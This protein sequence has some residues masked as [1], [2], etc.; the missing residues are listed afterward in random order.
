MTNETIRR[1]LMAYLSA[2]AML[3]TISSPV[4][5]QSFD[6]RKATTAVEKMIC[7]NGEL[8]LLDEQLARAFTDARKSVAASAIGQVAWLR[9]VR[10]QCASV[11]CLKA[12]HQARI[13]VLKKQSP[14]AP[15]SIDRLAGEWTRVGDTPADPSTLTISNATTTGF[16]FEVSAASGG[17]SGIIEGVAVRDDAEAVFKDRETKCNVRF[18][19]GSDYLFLSPSPD[20][21][22]MGGMGVTFHGEYRKGKVER[23]TP[24]L[25]ELGI[26]AANVTEKAFSAL[27]GKDYELFL[28][29]FHLRSDETDLDGLGA[30]VVSGGVRGLYTFMEAIVMSRSD[31]TI[32]AALI[33][34]DVVKYFSND[35]K[36]KTKL[37]I[38]IDKWRGNFA[39]KKVIFVP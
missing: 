19:W 14:V 33:D 17:N 11:D 7:A 10:N 8:S 15:L 22:S 32:L 12:A 34:D 31:G 1:V 38:T 26:L 30:K 27:V 35:A 5:A 23:R 39:D 6:C 16:A 13:A 29:R 24:T 18:S 37:P 28:S 2:G 20:C 36:F 9:D 21:L 25:T 4:A 3:A